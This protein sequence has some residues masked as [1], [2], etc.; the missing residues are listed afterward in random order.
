MFENF[1]KHQLREGILY[2]K[3]NCIEDDFSKAVEAFEEKGYKKAFSNAFGGALFVTLTNEKETASISYKSESKILRIVVE[4]RINLPFYENTEEKCDTLVTQVIIPFFTADCGMCYVIRTNDGSFVVID[5]GM[6][7]YDESEHFLEI[8]N[9]QNITDSKPVIKAWF[10][11]HPHSDHYGLFIDA[12]NRYSGKFVLENLIYNW[13]TEEFS[14]GESKNVNV[15][16]EIAEK[17]TDFNVIYARTGQKFLI[18]GN[19]FDILFTPDDCVPAHLYAN[20]I[21]LVIKQRVNNRS[22]LYLGDIMPPGSEILIPEYQK[23]IF[24]SE[25]VQVA[26][27][28][29]WGATNEFYKIMNPE[30]L[31]WPIAWYHYNNMSVIEQND[32]IIHS[33]T[34]K[35]IFYGSLEEVTLNMSEEV[36]QF[37]P[38]NQLNNP[39]YRA[40]FSKK[41]IIALNWSC[42]RGGGA[43]FTSPIAEFTHKG[44]N[45]KNPDEKGVLLEFVKPPFLKLVK[46]YTLTLKGE[47]K[48]SGRLAFVY[49]YPSP[50]GVTE[51]VFIDL[52]TKAGEFSY[53]IAVFGE[54]LT[55][56]LNGEKLKECKFVPAETN[57]IAIY[58]ENSYIDLYEVEL[59]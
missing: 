16:N 3:A 22:I 14:S 32:F 17:H 34:I 52:D 29:Y 18:G 51:D 4:E 5:G 40:D 37:H 54:D 20:D 11:T 33:D 53:E 25:I 31:L 46:D 26:H 49:N 24:K 57:G 45:L 19:E 43:P 2:K 58:F 47:I 8:L 35:N 9:S 13:S 38:Y 1:E 23:E 27:H 7:T 6:G 42:I 36:P 50:K 28:G 30:T 12:Y 55:I 59:K 10:I 39:I 15:F 48:K 44:I 41:S 21:S 56:N